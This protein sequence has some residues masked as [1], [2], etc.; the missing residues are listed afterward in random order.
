MVRAKGAPKVSEGKAPGPKNPTP[1][2]TED[3]PPG[4][5]NPTPK[6]HDGGP[7]SAHPGRSLGAPNPS[8][9]EAAA[10]GKEQAPTNANP[11]SATADIKKATHSVPAEKVDPEGNEPPAGVTQDIPAAQIKASGGNLGAPT[12]DMP[13]VE[14]APFTHGEGAAVV[15]GAL[16]IITN[17]TP[18]GGNPPPPAPDGP[19]NAAFSSTTALPQTQPPPP[20]DGPPNAMWSST[21]P[22]PQTPPPAPPDHPVLHM[23]VVKPEP[24]FGADEDDDADADER[25]AA[26]GKGTAIVYDGLKNRAANG[27]SPQSLT[28]I[29]P[30]D[31]GLTH[32]DLIT[33]GRGYT[34]RIGESKVIPDDDAKWLAGHPTYDIHK[35]KGA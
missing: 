3:K 33:K 32:E 34:L 4:G 24:A 9:A 28:L 30:A 16:S 18:G 15:P 31:E 35:V 26:L 1:K 19:P 10:K 2:T 7:G 22:L 25:D 6:T 27:L 17:Q 21:E 12:V 14:Q 20:P 13:K 5:P 23:D 11:G 8:G 29:V